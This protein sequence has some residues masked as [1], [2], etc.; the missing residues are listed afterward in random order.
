[1]RCRCYRRRT[2]WGRL[3]V[4][5]PGCRPTGAAPD[6]APPRARWR[7][8][9]RRTRF[10]FTPPKN[11]WVLHRRC[12]TVIENSGGTAPPRQALLAQRQRTP[13]SR[14]R[15]RV[16][17]PYEAQGRRRASS[18]A[19]YSGPGGSRTR[20]PPTW[21]GSKPGWPNWQRRRTQNPNLGVRLPLRVRA[22]ADVAVRGVASGGTRNNFGRACDDRRPLSHAA[23]AHLVERLTS[24]QEVS[25]SSPG[26]RSARDGARTPSRGTGCGAAR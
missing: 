22:A 19:R 13:L 10:P 8:S 9:R 1:M 16:Q 26:C 18:R 6:G 11:P 3:D 14:E 7:S 25:G 5:N 23:V 24:N 12:G 15:S 20:R 2:R 21:Q 17:F 4:R